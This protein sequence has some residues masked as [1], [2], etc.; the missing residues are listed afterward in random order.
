[1]PDRGRGGSAVGALGDGGRRAA[2]AHPQPRL[3]S[4]ARQPDRQPAQDTSSAVSLWSRLRSRVPVE[5]ACSLVA[6]SR[7][8]TA[9]CV[10][11]DSLLQPTPHTHACSHQHLPLCV[12]RRR[13][14]NSSAVLFLRACSSPATLRQFLALFLLFPLAAALGRITVNNEHH[15]ATR[16]LARRRSHA[17]GLARP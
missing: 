8:A 10:A 1:M 12:L 15:L 14:H 5:P 6:G 9:G 2:M 4:L 13:S 7:D 3:R 17:V 11:I 16:W